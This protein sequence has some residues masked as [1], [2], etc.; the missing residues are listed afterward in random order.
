M[1]NISKLTLPNNVTYDIKDNVSRFGGTNL[2]RYSAWGNAYEQ[3]AF[4]PDKK[5][6]VFQSDKISFLD[7]KTIKIE[8]GVGF[9]PTA[10]YPDGYSLNKDSALLSFCNGFLDT[11][12]FILSI[13]VYENTLDGPLNLMFSLCR[14]NGKSGYG[15]SILAGETGLKTWTQL[16]SQSAKVKGFALTSI[17]TLEATSGHIILGPPKIE[18][19]NKPTEWTP[20]PDDIVNYKDNSLIFF[21]YYS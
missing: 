13:W 8:A 20:C 12:R 19:G 6:D 11:D 17:Q 2:L 10:S 9:N 3:G 21:N 14:E 7:Y 18:L 4:G 5:T 16:P 15:K 1:T